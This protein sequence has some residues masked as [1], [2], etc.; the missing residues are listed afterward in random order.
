MLVSTVKSIFKW[1]NGINGE[2]KTIIIMM[3]AILI[4]NGQYSNQSKYLIDQYIY[5]AK[6]EK[7]VAEEYTKT[8]T[9]EI[10]ARIGQILKS[11]SDASNVLL[12]NYHNTVTSI[13]GLS[14]LYL[15]ALT[16]KTQGIDNESYFDVWKELSYVYYGEEFTRI[17]NTNYLVINDIEDV[18][19]SLPK[20]YKLLFI[21]NAKSAAFYPIKGTNDPIGMIVIL[22]K[23]KKVYP[24]DYYQENIIE[25]IQVF[26]SLLDYTSLKTKMENGN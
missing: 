18:K 19:A 20:I 23:H 13:H 7:L 12:L 17:H 3:L 6:S 24:M 5:T 26:A 4:L 16:E 9:P 10:N 22:Y 14:Y 2:V 25:Q 21:C 8:I 1:L 11:D 15:T